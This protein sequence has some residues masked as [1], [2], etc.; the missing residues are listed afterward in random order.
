[1]VTLQELNIKYW[2]TMVDMV[3][4]YNAANKADVKP[5]ECVDFSL[6]KKPFDNHP[7]FQ[8][9][10]GEYVF[11]VSIL[12]DDVLR[13][14]RPV[15]PG[16]RLWMKGVPWPVTDGVIIDPTTLSWNR[17]KK[18]RKNL[19]VNGNKLPAPEKTVLPNIDYH[20]IEIGGESFAYEDEDDYNK[21]SE[22]I[23]K[24]LREARDK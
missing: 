22:L 11:A 9:E 2:S 19:N 6:K 7:I 17:E 4:K 18:A 10:S 23:R 5:W 20:Y 14:H 24:I 12:Y 1:M 3:N 21:A 8:V 15:F 13:K 16:D